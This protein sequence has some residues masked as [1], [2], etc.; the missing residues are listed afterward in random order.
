ME[1]FF[2]TISIPFIPYYCNV[3]VFPLPLAAGCSTESTVFLLK[4]TAEI[5]VASGHYIPFEYL[6]SYVYCLLPSKEMHQGT[7]SICKSRPTFLSQFSFCL[8]VDP[9]IV[10]ITKT[11][12]VSDTLQASAE[13]V[14]S[15]KSCKGC[16]VSHFPRPNTKICRLTKSKKKESKVQKNK[17]SKSPQNEEMKA[18]KKEERK[19]LKNKA[20]ILM[21]K[22]EYPGKFKM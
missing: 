13:D 14:R 4:K 6:P 10:A 1:T 21:S 18:P 20:K 16:F 8:Q 22:K 11:L 7:V 2:P 5:P 15:I 17:E 12:S 9:K 3:V 19:P